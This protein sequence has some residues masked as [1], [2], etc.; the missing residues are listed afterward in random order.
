MW[1]VCLIQVSRRISITILISLVILIEMHGFSLKYIFMP[2]NIKTRYGGTGSRD[3]SS[4][5]KIWLD[6]VVGAGWFYWLWKI[7]FFFSHCAAATWNSTQN[8][9]TLISFLSVGQFKFLMS[10]YL[11]SSCSC[12]TVTSTF[13]MTLLIPTVFFP[14]LIG[15]LDPLWMFFFLLSYI[16]NEV[17]YQYISVLK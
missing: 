10:S 8:N 5:N 1:D 7:H 14:K 15:V 16:I 13:K 11:T 2:Y 4:M 9:L 12:F 17:L 3:R 6:Y